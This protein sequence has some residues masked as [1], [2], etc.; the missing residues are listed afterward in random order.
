[1][2]LPFFR[3][4][5]QV[6]GYWLSLV[7]A[8]HSLQSSIGKK[9]KARSQQVSAFE[10][11]I[12]LFFGSCF[13]LPPPH[14]FCNRVCCTYGICM[15]VLQ[16]SSVVCKL[17]KGKH[18]HSCVWLL[19]R[20]F[21]IFFIICTTLLELLDINFKSTKYHKVSETSCLFH[22]DITSSCPLQKG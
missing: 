4:W 15:A 12:T 18:T 21:I 6:W 20:T 7:K 9:R 16:V 11:F 13:F 14:Y 1:M 3:G 2:C 19:I 5:A 8:D 17:E 22:L 10:I